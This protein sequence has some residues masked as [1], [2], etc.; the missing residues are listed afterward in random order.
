[1]PASP[2]KTWLVVGASRGIGH[3][4]VR[5]LLIRGEK[6]Y[7]TVRNPTG[8][9]KSSFWTGYEEVDPPCTVL[10]CDVLSEQ[11]LLDLASGIRG[12]GTKIDHVVI[13]A[14]VLKYPN[15]ASEVSYEDFAFHLHSN[16]IGPIIC[17]QKLLSAGIDIGAIT[18]ISSDSGSAQ[19]FH[20]FEDGFA[21]YA[22]SKAGLNQMAR[23]LAAELERKGSEVVILLLHP[24]EVMTDM[25]KIEVGWD[26]GDQLTPEESVSGCLKTIESKTRIDSGTFWTWENK[27]YPW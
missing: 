23:H 25:A 17:A 10:S 27:R 4:F 2:K 8:E 20:E 11:S 22:A 13:N 12:Q 9:H 18:F 7:A 24:G 15:R 3:E 19:Q 26:I 1:M 21:A 14:G 6:V 16:T 5:Q